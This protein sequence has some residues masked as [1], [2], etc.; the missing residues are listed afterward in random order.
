MHPAQRLIIPLDV[1]S[2]DQALTL[3]DQI[4]QANFWKVGLE[5]FLATG[6]GVLQE[7]RQRQKR[8]FL[9]LKFHDIPNTVAAACRQGE[10]WSLDLLT[11]HASVGR[12]GLQAAQAALGGARLVAVTLLTSISAEQLREDLQVPLDPSA[13]VLHQARLAQECGLAGV[14]CSPQEAALVRQACGEDFLVVCPGVRPAWTDSQDQARTLT[15]SMALAA[16]ADYLVVGRPITRAP[17]PAQAFERVCSELAQ[18][19]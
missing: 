3:V 17:H 14:V 5:L 19:F 4:P 7:L 11:I 9:D 10:A 18:F 13:Y 15:P 1:A 8:V 6:P 2:L 16:G 12:Q